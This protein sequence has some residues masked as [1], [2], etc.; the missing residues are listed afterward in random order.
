MWH[1]SH[2]HEALLKFRCQPSFLTLQLQA[3]IKQKHMAKEGSEAVA[4]V[5]SEMGKTVLKGSSEGG[6]R[7]NCCSCA[8]KAWK[9]SELYEIQKPLTSVIPVQSLFKM[10]LLRSLHIELP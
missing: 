4:E 6:Y 9:K 3:Q 8:K 7:S 10:I 1:N 5:T 2:L